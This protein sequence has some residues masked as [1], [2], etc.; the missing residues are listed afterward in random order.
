MWNEQQRRD[1]ARRIMEGNIDRHPV[2]K[3]LTPQAKAA[4]VDFAV[5]AWKGQMGNGTAAELGIKHVTS[6]ILKDS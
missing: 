5:D 3:Q 1:N 2:G 4:A 6:A